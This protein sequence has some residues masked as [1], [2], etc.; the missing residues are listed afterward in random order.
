M[1]LSVEA[2]VAG[3]VAAGFLALTAGAMAQG[4]SKAQTGG[5]NKFGPM[6]N[7]GV[8]THMTQQGSNSS[9][10]GRTNAEENRQKFS[11]ENGRDQREDR[12]EAREQRSDR[13]EARR[14]RSQRHQE[15][16]ERSQQ[17]Q[18]KS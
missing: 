8:N 11:D 17:Q 9:A 15:R 1:K 18:G 16:R 10:F 5:Q 7:P 4:H 12:H 14:D 6:N 3:A 13:H 2:K